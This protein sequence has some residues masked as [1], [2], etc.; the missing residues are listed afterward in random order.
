MDAF[1]RSV[2]LHTSSVSDT[3][4]TVARS[5]IMVSLLLS[6]TGI[7]FFLFLGRL[8][9]LQNELVELI[10]ALFP[11]GAIAKEPFVQIAKPIP[12]EPI[13][14]LL[15]ARF[16]VHQTRRLQHTQVLR[17]LRLRKPKPRPDLAH[18][19]GTVLQQFDDSKP[20][21]LGKSSERFNH[22]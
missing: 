10:H 11:D 6:A 21:R 7:A 12:A 14:T 9:Q 3:R 8:A 1:A 5:R 18:G 15:S 13:K 17:H 4:S 16:H 19:A 20:A 22:E 2:C